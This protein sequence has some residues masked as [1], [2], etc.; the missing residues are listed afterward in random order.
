MTGPSRVVLLV[1]DEHDLRV[2]LEELLV[3]EGFEV[4]GAADGALALEWLHAGGRPSVVLLDFF[5]PRLNGWDFLERLR[6]LPE[7]SAVPVVG[8]S[9]SAVEHPGLAAMLRKPFELSALVAL[10]RA[11]MRPA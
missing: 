10:V 1:E 4:R 7:L 5:L 2:T 11:L 8:M 3:E 9:G 6:A